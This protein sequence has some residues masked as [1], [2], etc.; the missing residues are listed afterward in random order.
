MKA[1]TAPN[2]RF[3]QKNDGV[4]VF[5]QPKAGADSVSIPGIQAAPGTKIRVLGNGHESEFKQQGP[6]LVVSTRQAGASQGF[7]IGL[8]VSPPPNA[9]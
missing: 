5:V 7:A 1:S 9:V 8:R 6:E 4:Y 3:T 2:V